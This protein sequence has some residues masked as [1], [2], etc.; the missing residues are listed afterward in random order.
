MAHI[1]LSI[2][3]EGGLVLTFWQPNF[4][5]WLRA[6]APSLHPLSNYFVLHFPVDDERSCVKGSLYS[7]ALTLNSVLYIGPLKVEV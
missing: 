5:S 6:Y 4:D 3:L 2:C 1:T 7:G